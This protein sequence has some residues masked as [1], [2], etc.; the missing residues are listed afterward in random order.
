M[1]NPV[2]G[3]GWWVQGGDG[4]KARSQVECSSE[5]GEGAAEEHERRRGWPGRHV[6][7]CNLA[8]AGVHNLDVPEEPLAWPVLEA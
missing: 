2:D 5:G 6:V 4:G 1:I 3:E 7:L 8:A